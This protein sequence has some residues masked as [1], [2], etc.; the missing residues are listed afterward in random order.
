MLEHGL[1]GNLVAS[2][3]Q[4]RDNVAFIVMENV[5]GIDLIEVMNTSFQKD[6]TRDTWPGEELGKILLP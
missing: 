2:G 4:K 1:D 3:G 6:R 5:R